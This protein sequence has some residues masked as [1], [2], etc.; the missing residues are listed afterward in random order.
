MGFIQ[1]IASRYPTLKRDLAIA[2]IEQTPEAYVSTRVRGVAMLTLILTFGLLLLVLGLELP[3][4]VVPV[5]GLFA[6]WVFFS[7]LMRAVQVAIRK[8]AKEVDKDVLFAGRFLLIKL[9]S[10]KPLITAITEAAKRRARSGARSRMTAAA[11]GQ[12]LL[13]STTRAGR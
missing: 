6:G 12:G 9:N 13:G 1:E 4:W 5:G 3:L 7:I 2:R 11:C 8:Q 10:G